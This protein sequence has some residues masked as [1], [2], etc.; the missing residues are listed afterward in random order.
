[1]PGGKDR[2][3]SL[4]PFHGSKF[5]LIYTA[6]PSRPRRTKPENPREVRV[7]AVG[8][9]VQMTHMRVHTQKWSKIPQVPSTQHPN[10]GS[11]SSM[12]NPRSS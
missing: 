8:N 6:S 12:A 1:M 11:E 10:W 7:L 9:V 3:K 5:H 2:Q 4:N